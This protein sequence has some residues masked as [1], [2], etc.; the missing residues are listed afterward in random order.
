MGYYFVAGGVGG[1]PLRAVFHVIGLF[2][3]ELYV[4]KASANQP[5]AV[6]VHML[7]TCGAGNPILG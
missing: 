5:V 6:D 7:G 4:S 3:G 1:G 2:A